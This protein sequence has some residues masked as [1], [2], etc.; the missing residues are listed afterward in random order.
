MAMNLSGNHETAAEHLIAWARRMA[1]V[2]VLHHRAK[3][4]RPIDRFD[5]QRFSNGGQHNATQI[6]A[7]LT[8][9]LS[10]LQRFGE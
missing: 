3:V 2:I 7:V 8:G 10:E 1:F 9:S 4:Q 6:D 5:R